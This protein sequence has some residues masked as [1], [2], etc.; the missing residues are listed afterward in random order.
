MCKIYVAMKSE[1]LFADRNW[2]RHL[3]FTVLMTLYVIGLYPI[4]TENI[5]HLMF[6]WGI[7]KPGA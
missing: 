3:N 4:P 2:K 5:K 1:M 7:E 6:S